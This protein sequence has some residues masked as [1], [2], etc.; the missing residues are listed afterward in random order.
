MSYKR[1]SPQ[2]VEEGGT[3]LTT[4]TDHAVLIGSGTG[5]I[6]PVGPV[7]STGAL[8]AS[9]GVG[10]DPGFTTATYPLTT[11][12]NQ[13]L[14]S[15]ATN[16]VSEITTAANGVLITDASSVPSLLAAGTTGQVLTA[17]TGAPPSWAAA[18]T[19]DV[20]GPGSSTDRAVA[21]WNGTSGDALFDNPSITISS[22]GEM[23]NTSQPA[24]SAYQASSGTNLTGDGTIVSLGDTSTSGAMTE[25]F[26]QNA[27]FTTGGAGVPAT[28]TAPVTG[29]YQFNFGIQLSGLGAGHTNAFLRLITSNRTYD[30]GGANVGGART[31][32]NTYN[33]FGSC[34]AD[35]DAS[36]TAYVQFGVFNSTKTVGFTGDA[37]IFT[38]FSGS[39]IC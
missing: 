29:K 26:D 3:G 8:L 7:A 22:S 13:I 37:T 14:Y 1:I 4:I 39:L 36:D 27:D 31:N 6:T 25:I 34:L 2:P 35:M 10:S 21:T 38:F 11:T 28:F 23:V 16:T 33:L 9:N 18:S 5:A 32:S 17:T 15:S 12:A 24:F 30:F 20:S 19:G